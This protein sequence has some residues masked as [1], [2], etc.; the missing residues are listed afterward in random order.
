M[1]YHLYFQK[2]IQK[3]HLFLENI[4]KL[5]DSNISFVYVFSDLTDSKEYWCRAAPSKGLGSAFYEGPDPGPGLLYNV[6]HKHGE[7]STE[8]RILYS[9]KKVT[10]SFKGPF[11]FKNLSFK[12]G[13]KL[14]SLVTFV[15]YVN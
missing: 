11:H 9:L 7:L 8:K 3:F 6:F 15:R 12:A 10:L 13:W 2:T 5:R 4:D 14:H 1:F